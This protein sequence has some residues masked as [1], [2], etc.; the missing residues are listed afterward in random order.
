[1]SKAKEFLFFK[2]IEQQKEIIKHK[3]KMKTFV[4]DILLQFFLMREKKI[5]WFFIKKYSSS[6]QNSL[7]YW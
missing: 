1:M 6:A 5:I 2:K 7:S 3:V 4:M